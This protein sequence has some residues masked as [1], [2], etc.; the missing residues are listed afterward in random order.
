MIPS[1]GANSLQGAQARNAATTAA[2][3]LSIAELLSQ[4]GTS[5]NGLSDQAAS[6]REAEYGRNLIG[7][8][9]RS[10]LF[11]L[12]VRQF[13]SPMILLLIGAAVLSF[14]LESNPANS[15]I[16]LA[17]VFISGLLGFWQEWHAADAVQR[18][19]SV[20]EHKTTVV[21]DG[22]E[23]IVSAADIVPGD[24]LSLSAGSG[25][26]ADCRLISA[27]DLFVD[28]AALTGETF[29]AEKDP[30]EGG[31]DLPLI[32]RPNALF[33]GTH[34]VSGSG[35]A[36]VVQT[37]RGTEFGAIAGRLRL[38]PGE[39]DFEHGVRRFGYFLMEVT[40]ILVTLIFC[41][42]VAT[43]RPVLDSF[44]FAL[45]LAVG[46]TPQLLPAI[47]SVNLAHGAA[48]MAE[49]RVI[50]KRLA[51]IENFGSMDVLCSDKTG[52]LT[53]GKV[54]IETAL[55]VRGHASAR[56]LLHACLN[57]KFETGYVNPIDDALRA[58]CPDSS[59]WTRLDEIP[60]DF[61]R[62]RL[63][64][65]A[66]HEG[67]RWLISK[68]ALQ[69][70]LDV[71]RLADAGSGVPLPLDQANGSIHELQVNLARQGYR[72]LGVAIREMPPEHEILRRTDEAEM[73][74]LGVISLA[75]PPKAGIAG[76]VD[77]LRNLGIRLKIITGDNALVAETVARGVGIANP[78]VLSGTELRNMLD[79]ALAVRVEETDVFAEVEPNQ[80]E[81][82]VRA[83]RA[84]GHVV[85]YMG[86]GINDAS[87]MH[88]ADISISVQTAVDVAKEAADIVLLEQ[89][90]SVLESGVRASRQTFGNT[91]KYVFMAT[92]ANFGNMFSMAGASFFLP[93]LPLLPQQILLMNLLTDTPELA[94]ATDRVDA[95]W[96][97]KPRRW[98]IALI[99]HFMCVF[100]LLSSLF[101]FLTFAI[102]I[103]LL[104]T[105]EAEFRTAWFIESVASATLI[106]LVVRTRRPF[107]FSRPS[108]LLFWS[109]CLTILGAVLLIYSPLGG[110]V[111]FVPLTWDVLATMAGVIL[112]Y[113]LSAEA[114]KRR[115]YARG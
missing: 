4:L 108:M 36:V 81:R 30:A 88:A 64:I 52:T 2:W 10:D 45:A 54:R 100:G 48:Q 18:L 115:F 26:P 101:D 61:L 33:L 91:L 8:P 41:F 69:N 84:A 60:Y 95:E 102:L 105:S 87:A 14:F 63:S 82:I 57:S 43:H 83:L 46:L 74:F 13:A 19:L 11:T 70:I 35:R 21:R 40:L 28:E 73:T 104:K 12:L 98:D 17:I 22:R 114:V 47:I 77:S 99:R 110:V 16:I 55:D 76:V 103:A 92:S 86:D 34:V 62:K 27:R 65:L 58:A 7:A 37:G 66:E 38:A 20:I 3:N 96:I 32:R 6:S 78:R 23:E 1:S 113:V 79:A 9:A 5:V 72:T 111:G 75:D 85:G 89:D 31:P 25:V 53:E 71:C 42:N 90:L 39:T 109:S 49:Q 56:V 106:V 67:R 29:P 15:I 68:G 50:V 80:K 44:L 59:G 97:E 24:I 107:L 94:I 93:F 51:A 112:L